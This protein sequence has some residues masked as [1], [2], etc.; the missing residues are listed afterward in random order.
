MYAGEGRLLMADGGYGAFIYTT[1][2]LPIK[3]P[4]AGARKIH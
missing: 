1:A 4:V 3:K 2:F